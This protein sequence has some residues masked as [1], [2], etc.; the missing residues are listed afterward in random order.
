MP[1]INTL[2]AD[3]VSQSNPTPTTP[4]EDLVPMVTGKLRREKGRAVLTLDV[5]RLHTYLDTL[6][7]GKD[8]AYKRYSN[9]P[10]SRSDLIDSVNHALVPK[11]LC[12]F[13]YKKDAAGVEVTGTLEIDLLRCY[14]TPPTEQTLQAIAESVKDAT[15][16]VITHYQPVE[17]SISISGKKPR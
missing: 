7:V 9:A 10:A 5:S 14:S 8:N 4:Q 2:P 17:I 13:D 12:S 1:E 15:T 11:A 3:A 6:N 16:A